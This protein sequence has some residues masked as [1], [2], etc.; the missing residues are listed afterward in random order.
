MAGETNEISRLVEQISREDV[1]AV[2]ELLSDAP[3]PWY[4]CGGWAI[5]LL[6]DAP[7]RPHSDLEIGI[8]RSDQDYLHELFPEWRLY[9][10]IPRPGQD[11]EIIPW[12]R[13]EWLSLPVHQVML[14]NESFSPPEFEFFLN[15]IE[16]ET[17]RSR[18]RPEIHC[19]V[20]ALIRVSPSGIPVAAPEVQLLFKSTHHQD[21]DEHDLRIALPH[22][23]AAQKAWL[24]EAIRSE[25]P[26]DPWLQY[27]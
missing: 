24:A 25:R 2:A 9:K 10:F 13:R 3:F 7:T 20:K 18:R 19:P 26:N 23:S 17:W 14:Q 15:E 4:V 16:D 8:G 1:G 22:M 5:D 12:S 6:V 21:K 27:L 11:A